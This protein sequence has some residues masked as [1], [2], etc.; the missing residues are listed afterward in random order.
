MSS[1]LHNQVKARA[2]ILA[3]MLAAGAGFT[4]DAW[5]D[6]LKID[7]VWIDRITVVRIDDTTITYTVRGSETSDP[8][9]KIQGLRLDSYTDLGDAQKA[10]EEGKPADAVRLLRRM[11][12]TNPRQVWARQYAERVLV[13][14]LDANNAPTEAVLT[15]LKLARERA[16]SAYLTT[17][18]IASL[19]RASDVVKKDIRDRLTAAMPQLRGE[20]KTGAEQMLAVL[21]PQAAPVATEGGVDANVPQQA[22]VV[23]LATTGV[24]KG[25]PKDLPLNVEGVKLYREGK[26]DEALKWVDNQL[27]TAQT[28][29]S[30]FF[31]LRGL[32]L[33]ELAEKSNNETMFKD[34]GVSFMKSAIYFPRDSYAGPAYL[35]TA[36]VHV[37]LGKFKEARK[38]Y[39]KAEQRI[40]DEPGLEEKATKLLQDI[41]AGTQ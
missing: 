38:L 16:P 14:A 34:A 20:A 23:P 32:I 10:L 1:K 33:F 17:P 27:L 35:E 6:A 5:A 21:T 4:T 9:S 41:E 25:I 22:P 13:Q 24:V 18:P 36:R 12:A 37:K 15:Y 30:F 8:V 29:F 26:L 39:A 19:A 31:F 40:A 3:A 28:N 11:I 7:G 2:I